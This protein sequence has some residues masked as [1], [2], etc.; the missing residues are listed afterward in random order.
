MANVDRPNGATAIDSL[1]GAPVVAKMNAYNVDSSNATAIFPGDFMQ[2]EADG[3]VAVATAGATNLIIGVCGGVEVAAPTQ[4]DGFLSN[5]NIGV[6][7][8]P[9]YLPVSTAGSVL[10]I[11]DPDQLFL[12]Q[13]AGTITADDQG[14]NA[15]IV[16]GAGS[17]TTGRSA[18]E[19]NATTTST[20]NQVRLIRPYKAADNDVTLADSKWIVQITEHF[21]RQTSGVGV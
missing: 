21:Y 18:H 9:G 3:N 8:H 5:N 10:I 20:I 13:A 19:I 12:V 11:D 15:P 1:T 2:L 14:Q 17:T 7:E 16:A 4:E 6:T